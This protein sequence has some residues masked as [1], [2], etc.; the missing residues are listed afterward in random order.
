MLAQFDSMGLSAHSKSDKTFERKK[1]PEIFLHFEAFQFRLVL[2]NQFRLFTT[3]VVFGT[4]LLRRVPA[5]PDRCPLTP[6]TLHQP[7]GRHHDDQLS[8]S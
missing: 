5:D 6:E 1:I 4:S 7:I 3:K 2:A 8:T